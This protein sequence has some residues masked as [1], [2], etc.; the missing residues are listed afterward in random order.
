MSDPSSPRPPALPD[1]D[2]EPMTPRLM[3]RLFVV[4]L[5]IVVMIVFS[6]AAV[7]LLFGWISEGREENIDVLIE[8][9]ESGVG[10]LI[11]G[12][13][14]LPKDREVWQAA[15][16]LAKRLQSDDPAEFPPEKRP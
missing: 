15:N 14:M 5:L 6:S 13:A 16:D 8:K 2:K 4:P 9:I 11:G 12:M 7:V 3:A 10:D 1:P